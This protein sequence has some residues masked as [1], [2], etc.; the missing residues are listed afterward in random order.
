[1]RTQ[2]VM[3]G[4]SV[5]TLL[6]AVVTAVLQIQ[7]SGTSIGDPEAASGTSS[8]TENSID[9]SLRS[10]SGGLLMTGVSPVV[11][12]LH[13][14]P[15]LRQVPWSRN[16]VMRAF[17][18]AGS[19]LSC[20]MQ[21]PGVNVVQPLSSPVAGV[22]GPVGRESILAIALQLDP[23]ARAS[24]PKATRGMIETYLES[25]QMM[26]QP[27]LYH[28]DKGHV[29]F[30]PQIRAAFVDKSRPQYTEIAEKLIITTMSEFRTLGIYYPGKGHP[31]AEDMRTLILGF[32]YSRAPAKNS[33]SESLPEGEKDFELLFLHRL[34]TEDPSEI[35]IVVFATNDGRK[36]LSL[37]YSLDPK[38]ALPVP[39]IAAQIRFDDFTMM[40]LY[41]SNPVVTAVFHQSQLTL[42]TDSFI[43]MTK[44]LGT[45]KPASA[46]E[47]LDDLYHRTQ[48]SAIKAGSEGSGL[49][50]ETTTDAASEQSASEGSPSKVQNEAAAEENPAPASGAGSTVP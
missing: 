44:G 18:A 2:F 19:A 34:K 12:E 38:A 37:L 26:L 50:A 28:D 49:P 3:A 45:G 42:E 35:R 22:R 7:F 25:H 41:P 32:R 14:I 46:D 20:I 48:S 27:V 24:L 11:P 21:E 9:A 33:E 29:F 30:G 15:V 6:V 23:L 39:A 13:E 1:M 40:G 31:K 47:V 10:A 43:A 36:K 16:E 17:G 5:L 8:L 4:L